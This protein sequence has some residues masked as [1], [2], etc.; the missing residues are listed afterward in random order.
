[1]MQQLYS[2]THWLML[3]VFCHLMSFL[4]LLV[5]WQL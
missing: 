4:T 3:G 2:E 1:M 5:I